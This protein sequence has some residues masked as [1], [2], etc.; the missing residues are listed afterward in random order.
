MNHKGWKI[1]V[2]SKL[3]FFLA[4]HT[5]LLVLYHRYLSLTGKIHSTKVIDKIFNYKS[6][7]FDKVF[8]TRQFEE[9]I[10]SV[11]WVFFLLFEARKGQFFS[12]LLKSRTKMKLFAIRVQEF[13]RRTF[14]QCLKTLLQVIDIEA[15][16][17]NSWRKT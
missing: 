17:R 2:V 4:F 11:H 9:K 5:F 10:D 3:W 7:L 12:L 14:I 1:V 13:D 8:E 6:T 16:T 15:L